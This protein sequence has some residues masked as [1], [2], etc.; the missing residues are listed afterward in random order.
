[1]FV[2]ENDTPSPGLLKHQVKL[3]P[4]LKVHFNFKNLWKNR[5]Y[6]QRWWC[7]MHTSCKREVLASAAAGS[8]TCR[9]VLTFPLQQATLR[10]AR[11]P[12]IN[13]YVINRRDN[14]SLL[15]T[16]KWLL[17]CRTLR[18][19]TNKSLQAGLN[20]RWVSTCTLLLIIVEFKSENFLRMVTP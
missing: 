9:R 13:S 8:N 11:K 17:K 7:H 15:W 14:F 20:T 4:F 1:M 6:K 2:L 5:R 3:I 16:V 19:P 10:S 12:L 18:V